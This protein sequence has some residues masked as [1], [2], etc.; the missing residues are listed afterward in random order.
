M[1]IELLLDCYFLILPYSTCSKVITY[2]P[3]DNF[4]VISASQLFCVPLIL[5]VLQKFNITVGAG[6]KYRL[7]KT[8]IYHVLLISFFSTIF[9]GML[10]LLSSI[11][12]KHQ[13]NINTFIIRNF[14]GAII[15]IISMKLI[16][17]LLD[18]FKILT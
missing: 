4:F 13:I 6:E 18:R 9:L 8:N 7:D 17:S 12:Y 1:G 2:I 16:V 14:I 10:L 15:L 3:F 5:F 11:F